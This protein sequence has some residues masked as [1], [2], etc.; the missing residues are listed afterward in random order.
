MR[1]V[2]LVSALCASMITACFTVDESE[3]SGADAT[4]ARQ[5]FDEDVEPL[6]KAVCGDCHAN[7]SDYYGAP[8]YLTTM[9]DHY[10]SLISRGEFVR[11][12]VENSLL[13]VKGRDLGHPGGS[14]TEPQHGKVEGWLL[15]EANDRFGGRCKGPSPDPETVG[16]GGGGGSEGAGTDT[17]ST[18]LRGA[19]ALK[20]FGDCMTLDDWINTGMPLVA[21]QTALSQNEQTPCYSCH[22]G[23]T[24]SNWMPN[25]DAGG[26]AQAIEQAFNKMR[27]QYGIFNLVRWTVHKEDGTFKDIV[28]SYQWRDIGIQPGAHPPYALQPEYVRAIEDWYN[29][30]YEK[31]KSGS[32]D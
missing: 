32:C 25:P 16:S 3:L 29:L 1:G 20:Q 28:P 9:G 22:S 15:K 23:G 12:D 13:L 2:L 31:W 14:L 5:L 6:L 30:T 27:E 4:S 7:P 11:C 24:G 17:S 21:K 19:D 8:D 10:T 18:P 26:A